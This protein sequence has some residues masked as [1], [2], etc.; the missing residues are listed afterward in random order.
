VTYY[1]AKKLQESFNTVRKN[2]LTIAEE[3]PAEKY[4]YRASP[5]TKSVG[6][7]LAHLAT[8]PMWQIAMHSEHV[9]F[10]DFATFG[11]RL[12]EAAA[13]EQALA[14]DKEAIVKALR[15]NGDKLSAFFG[16]LSEET[17]QEVVNFPPP[18]QP[19]A[20]TRFEMLLGI[21]E[22]EMHHRAQLMLIERM[23]GIVPHLTRAREAFR[24]QAAGGAR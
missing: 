12:A 6:E 11:A 5:D 24:A 14:G 2:T 15:E 1:G 4:A 23:L 9:S 8:A 3:V 19:P 16:G 18:V 10:V 20:K 22:H 13:A 7:M 21:K 17:L